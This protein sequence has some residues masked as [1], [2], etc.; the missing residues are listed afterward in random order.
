MTSQC[1]KIK[2]DETLSRNTKPSSIRLPVLPIVVEISPL[3]SRPCTQD[4]ATPK[5]QDTAVN[6]QPGRL[7]RGRALDRGPRGPAPGVRAEPQFASRL[8]VA[9]G[10]RPGAEEGEGVTPAH[11]R[12]HPKPRR[13][14]ENPSA[15]RAARRVSGS[16]PCG[17]SP[18]AARRAGS[19]HGRRCCLGRAARRVS[20]GTS[21]PPVAGA[22]RPAD[23][24][25]PRW[26]GADLRVLAG[27]GE[28][29]VQRQG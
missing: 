14:C 11:T 6:R 27:V 21:V 15:L 20:G 1:L 4:G 22:L 3:L 25:L 8:L 5:S 9:S 12:P 16:G 23:S 2:A 19:A 24:G 7:T 17:A 10:S 13:S 26:G 18:A 29:Q 28:R